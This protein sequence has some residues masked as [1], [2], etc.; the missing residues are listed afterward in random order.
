MGM[1]LQNIKYV[2]PAVRNVRAKSNTSAFTRRAPKLD[3]AKARQRWWIHV[4]FNSDI[5]LYIFENTVSGSEVRLVELKDLFYVEDP[6][7]PDTA[8]MGEA[9][10]LAETIIAQLNGATQILCPHF[11]GV[12]IESM[13]ELLDNGTGRGIVSYP[14]TLHGSSTYPDIETFLKGPS[15]P[16]TSILAAMNLNTD[17]QEALYYLGAEGNAWANLYKACEVV[18]DHAGAAKAM[19][20][21]G[22]CSRSAWER[23]SRTANHQEAIGRFSRHARSQVEPPPDPMTVSEARRFVAE[24]VSHWIRSLMA[25]QNEEAVGSDT[26]PDPPPAPCR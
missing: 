8:D 15:A 6:R 23:F 1:G 21:S 26:W 9:S 16:I 13:I 3:Y 24:L 25:S 7:I 2:V 11:L 12:R 18:E 10:R 19:F 20:Q 17:V 4:D 5:D 22:W 14:I